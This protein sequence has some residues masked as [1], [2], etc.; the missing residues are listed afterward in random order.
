MKV[1]HGQRRSSV[2]IVLFAIF[3]LTAFSFALLAQ[4]QLANNNTRITRDSG[5]AP[6]R[7]SPNAI[8]G[9]GK[10]IF[11]RDCAHCHGQRGDGISPNMRTLHPAPF[12]L[13]SFE[14]SESYI[15][16]VVRDGLPGSDMPAWHL[17]SEEEV[18]D[19]SAYTARLGRLDTLPLQERYASPGVLLEAGHRIYK[20]H[21]VTC[22]GEHGQG[23]G[24]DASKH[25]PRPA[26][27]TEMRPAFTAARHIIQNGVPGTDMPSWPLLT[28]P[29]IQAVTF[30]IRTF[31]S[32]S[33]TP[34]GPR[35]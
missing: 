12:D 14:L 11:V 5:T 8:L 2:L 35:L 7:L 25:L 33:S 16:H 10:Q 1:I 6:S 26:S 34:S 20:M 31:Y 24:P 30:Y 28:D 32:A 13:T 18:H 4:S 23:D 9:N 27:F 17:G 3:V 15:R 19:V 21:C 29:E 22:H